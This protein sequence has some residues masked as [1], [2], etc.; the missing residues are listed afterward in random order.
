MEKYYQ[1]KEVYIVDGARSPFLKAKGEPGPFA[2]ADLAVLAAR[3]L[4]ER[5]PIQ[6]TD[7]EE[8][9]F[10]CVM[11][12]PDETNIGRVISYR[13]GCGKSVPA[14]TVQRNC[15]SGLQAIDEGLKDIALGRHDLVLV[16]GTDAMSRAPL[17]Y[18]ENAVKWFGQ[19]AATKTPLAKIMQ[20]LKWRPSLFLNPV[21][22][23]LHGL[24][25]PLVCLSMGQTAENIAHDLSVTRE[26][27]DA[28]AVES[29]KRLAAA[30]DAGV[31]KEEIIPAYFKEAV[32]TED[33]GLRRDAST[34]KLA[35]LKPFFDKRFGSVTAGNSSQITDGATALI[36]ASREAVE[37]YKLPV[38]GKIL[39]IHWA[40]LDPAYMGLGPVYAATP[41][42]ERNHLSKDD[43]DY[44]EINEAFAAQVLGCLKAWESPEF[45][46]E[47]LGLKEAFGKIDQERLNIDGGA[48]AMGHPVGA[49]GARIV[50]HLLNV[51]KRK[52]AKL[53]LASICIGGGLGGAMLVEN[54]SET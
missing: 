4:I 17:L 53:G 49:S 43:I 52:D 26:E 40:G 12:S 34:A 3:E 15:A 30:I 35:T 7:I 21:I 39:D 28:F 24:T 45:C 41:L 6:A 20:L 2:A 19:M 32:Y 9:I 22:G 1:G 18:N 51:L 31:F 25:D 46:R 13:V 37:K 44:W 38:L 11:P 23:L 29:H 54:V 27:M 42:L 14:Y 33:T 47:K 36:L 10:G 48:I 16:G 8:T 5:L 50:L